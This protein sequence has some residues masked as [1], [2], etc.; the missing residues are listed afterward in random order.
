MG[1]EVVVVNTEVRKKSSKTRHRRVASRGLELVLRGR[2][3][4]DDLCFSAPTSGEFS[5]RRCGEAVYL[6]VL[7]FEGE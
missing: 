1:G 3:C 7:I 2:M 5:D 4:H 6:N